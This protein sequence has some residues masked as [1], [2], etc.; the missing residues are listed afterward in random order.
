MPS[1]VTFE[2]GVEATRSFTKGEMVEGPPAHPRPWGLWTVEVN[3]AEV[4]AAAKRLWGTIEKAAAKVRSVASEMSARVTL[5]IWWDPPEGE[6]GFSIPSETLGSLCA[7]VD[8]VD[9][10]LP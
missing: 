1:T 7:L 5:S 2:L 3:D 10:Y 9:V 8:Q 4:E 6:G